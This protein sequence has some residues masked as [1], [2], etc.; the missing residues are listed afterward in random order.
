[1]RARNTNLI[2]VYGNLGSLDGLSHL[3]HAG[4]NNSRIGML[5][6]LSFCAGP[7]NLQRGKR[8]C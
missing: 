6:S 5:R 7:M 4:L 3:S 1:M 8:F 2:T